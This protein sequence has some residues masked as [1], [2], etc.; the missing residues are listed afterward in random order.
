MTDI[1][2]NCQSKYINIST[3]LINENCDISDIFKGVKQPTQIDCSISIVQHLLKTKYSF[4]KI[5]ADLSQLDQS[6]NNKQIIKQKQQVLQNSVNK[7]L[8]KVIEDP[9]IELSDKEQTIW[10]DKIKGTFIDNK[11]IANAIQYKKNKPTFI[12]FIKNNIKP[13]NNFLNINFI[14]R[15]KLYVHTTAYNKPELFSKELVDEFFK[16]NKNTGTY[17]MVVRYYNVVD[18]MHEFVIFDTNNNKI[19]TTNK[20]AFTAPLKIKDNVI[21]DKNIFENYTIDYIAIESDTP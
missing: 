17:G 20:L 18:D 13:T 5:P 9:N 16:R 3:W 21:R 10:Y 1:F 15:K 6:I 12:K 2:K 19:I 7:I 8:S 11:T 14:E 4:L